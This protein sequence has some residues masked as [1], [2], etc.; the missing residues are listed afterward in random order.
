[1]YTL[2]LFKLDGLNVLA[3]NKITRVATLLAC[4]ILSQVDGDDLL[5]RNFKEPIEKN[6]NHAATHRLCP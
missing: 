5:Q 6:G 4:D 1:M 2:A 3:P